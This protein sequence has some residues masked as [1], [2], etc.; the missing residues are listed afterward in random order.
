[1]LGIPFKYTFPSPSQAEMELFDLSGQSTF[2]RSSKM[3]SCD[4]WL[5]DCFHTFQQF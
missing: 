4:R 2:A 1:M 3:V 5:F